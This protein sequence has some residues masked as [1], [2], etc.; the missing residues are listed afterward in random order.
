MTLK[1][2]NVPICKALIEDIS[3]ALQEKQPITTK[4][5]RNRLPEQVRDFGHLFAG[6][7]GANDL[8]PSHGTLDPAINLKYEEEKKLSHLGG[9]YTICPE[10][11]CWFYEK[12]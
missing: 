5:L 12:R 7:G 11:N 1:M 3:R 10:N 4:N 9:L 6:D 2:K 8:P